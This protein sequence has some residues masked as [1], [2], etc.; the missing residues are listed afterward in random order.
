VRQLVDEKVIPREARGEYDKDVCVRA[1]IRFLQQSMAAK[2]SILGDGKV[3]NTKGQRAS[4]LN[5]QIERE[6]LDLAQ[7]KGE[8][9]SIEDHEKVLSSLVV[10]TKANVTAVGARVAGKVVGETDRV[11][12][13]R[14]ID[15]EIHRALEAL[16]KVAPMM[17][18]QDTTADS[19]PAPE[20]A[21]QKPA[22]RKGRK[23]KKH[24]EGGAG[25]E[26]PTP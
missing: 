19:P 6:A 9:M 10:E 23:R 15:D 18:A 13:Q 26:A 24:P 14:E 8:V 7:A 16:A 21:Q 2:S 12:V 17:P 5:I 20:P 22:P 3:V 4:L 25:P 1:Y 11:K